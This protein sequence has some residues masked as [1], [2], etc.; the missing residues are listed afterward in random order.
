[1]SEQ[2]Q[3]PRLHTSCVT[4]NPEVI[5]RS[6]SEPGLIAKRWREL[7]HL[8]E[9]ALRGADELSDDVRDAIEGTLVTFAGSIA[10]AKARPQI[11]R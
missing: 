11:T 7:E 1:M 3:E 5:R 9:G 10:R 6:R 4:S 2:T 8:H